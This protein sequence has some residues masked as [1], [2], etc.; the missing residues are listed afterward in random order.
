VRDLYG[1]GTIFKRREKLG[2]GEFPADCPLNDCIVRVHYIAKTLPDRTSVFSALPRPPPASASG[3]A[4]VRPLPRTD[5]REDGEGNPLEFPV[6]LGLQP[7]PL[8]TT[9]RL[10]TIKEVSMVHGKAERL[11]R[12]FAEMIPP[13]VAPDQQLEWEVELDS[14]DKPPNWYKITY[15]EALEDVKKQKEYGNLLFKRGSFALAKTKYHKTACNIDGLRGLEHEQ[16]EILEEIKLQCNLNH[17]QCCLKQGE[18][19]E[20]VERVNKV[21]K[22][23]P[24]NQK[25]LFKRALAHIAT[26]FWEEA[27]EDL[28]TVLEIDPST[29]KDVNRERTRLQKLEQHAADVEKK[30][31][32]GK[33]IQ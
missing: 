11:Y 17:A 20:A 33:L 13:G 9:V 14:F 5:T 15:P 19:F 27:K 23:H 29:E 26:G 12:G 18:N 10:M 21:L 2:E 6:G 4:C 24:R 8:E 30:S 31:L 32:K 3:G 28:T 7:D 22:H 1:D 25:A 16:W